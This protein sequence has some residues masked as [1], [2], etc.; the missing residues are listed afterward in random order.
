MDTKREKRSKFIK[1][2]LKMISDHL[3]MNNFGNSK[4]FASNTSDSCSD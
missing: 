3:D 4:I 1:E 2:L